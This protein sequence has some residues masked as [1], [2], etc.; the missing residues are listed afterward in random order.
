MDI[1]EDRDPIWSPETMCQ[2][3]G[4]SLSTWRRVYRNQLPIVRISAKRIGARRSAWRHAL[5]QRTEGRPA[6]AAR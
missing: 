3:A 6:D 2:D 1:A 4:I 5:E